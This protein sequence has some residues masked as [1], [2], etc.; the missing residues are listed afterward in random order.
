[1]NAKGPIEVDE[2]LVA[3]ADAAL[4]KMAERYKEWLQEDVSA[5]AAAYDTGLAV[6]ATRMEQL[7]LIADRAHNIKGQGATFGFDLITE[8]G[9]SLCT[10]ANNRAHT[11]DVH[12]EIVH[13]HIDALRAV[14]ANDLQ[15]EGGELGK[16]LRAMLQRATAKFA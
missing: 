4:S 3:K 13:A 1:M 12:W 8:I 16:N 10:F 15:G 5:L 6:A 7:R 14:Q 9:A 11:A 2:S